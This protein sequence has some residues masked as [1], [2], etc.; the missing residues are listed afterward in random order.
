M[1]ILLVDDHA[2]FRDGMHYVLRQLDEHVDILD[3]GNFPAALTLAEG[4]PDLDLILLD[5]HLPGSAGVPSVKLLHTHHPAIPIVVIS[6]TDQRDDIEKVMNNGAMGFISKM[7]SSD[8]MVQALRL[9]LDGGVYLSPQLLQLAISG[10]EQ[11]RMDKRTWRTN[12]FGLT[13]RQMEVLLCMADGMSNKDIGDA[14]GLAEGT[15]KIHVA[16]IFSAL[17]VNKRAEAVQTARH[18]GILTETNAPRNS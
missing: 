9:V 3:A 6:G 14:I 17:R 16:A 13:P 12:E 8:S 10:I 1:K 2:L 4:N 11:G 5:L 7:S 15:V 18:L